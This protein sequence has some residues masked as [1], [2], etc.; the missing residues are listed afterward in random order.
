[1]L[2]QISLNFSEISTFISSPG[3]ISSRKQRIINL[4]NSVE[5]T[6]LL[7]PQSINDLLEKLIIY[8]KYEP[9]NA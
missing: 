4:D 1:M 5:I 9:I 7:L 3:K 2:V 8:N 6:N